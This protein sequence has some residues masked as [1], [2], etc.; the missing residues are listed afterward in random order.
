MLFCNVIAPQAFW[1]G[2]AR[3]SIM[4]VFIIAVVINTGMWLERILIVWNTLSHGYVPSMWRLYIPTVWDWLITFGSLGFF[5]FLFLIF[6]R[7]VPAVSMHEVRDL[8]A[9]EIES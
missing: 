4:S 5:I 6:V 3:R 2:A 1:I 9:E 8:V 7:L